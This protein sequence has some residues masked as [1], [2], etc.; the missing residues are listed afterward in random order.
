MALNDKAYRLPELVGSLC[1]RPP[2]AA[3]SKFPR[4]PGKR[5]F[6]RAF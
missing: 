2:V 3:A 6:G 4:I 1:R 5:F